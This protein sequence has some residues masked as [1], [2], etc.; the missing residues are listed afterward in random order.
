[1]VQVHQPAAGTLREPG[2]TI[3][4]ARN[5]HLVAKACG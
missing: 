2:D 4:I 1:M 5:Q 3:H